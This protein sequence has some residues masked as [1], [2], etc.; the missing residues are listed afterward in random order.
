MEFVGNLRLLGWLTVFYV[1]ISI[2][3]LVRQQEQMHECFIGLLKGISSNQRPQGANIGN[4]EILFV[5]WL[6]KSKCLVNECMAVNP[7]YQITFQN[8]LV[9]QISV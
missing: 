8:D 9:K 6:N 1:R 7:D 2:E 5:R 4:N 3:L